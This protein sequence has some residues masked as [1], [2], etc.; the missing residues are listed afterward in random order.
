M[1]VTGQIMYFG[2]QRPMCRWVYPT[3]TKE[4]SSYGLWGVKEKGVHLRTK[5][6][7]TRHNIESQI[8]I[9][10]PMDLRKSNLLTDSLSGLTWA[11]TYSTTKATISKAKVLSIGRESFQ[12]PKLL[13]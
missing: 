3:T 10:L 12:I 6:M 5:L 2:G 4:T 13:S 11:L 9:L 8:R 7:T 1:A